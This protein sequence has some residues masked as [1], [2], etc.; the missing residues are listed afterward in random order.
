M[1]TKPSGIS[2]KACFA[3]LFYLLIPSCAVILILQSYPELSKDRFFTIIHW[4]VPT[5]IVIVTLAQSSLFFPKGTV[6]RLLINLGFVAATMVWVYGL[7]GGG[8][9]IT[10]QWN[11]Y[12]FSIHMI[13]YV[14]LIIAVAGLN[15]LYYLLEWRVFSQYQNDSSLEKTVPIAVSVNSQN[16]M[17]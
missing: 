6:K 14:F 9:V 13:K 8:V 5:S 3:L 17:S 2:I 7:L 4:I 10:N 1:S 16:K 15:T 11:E 12:L